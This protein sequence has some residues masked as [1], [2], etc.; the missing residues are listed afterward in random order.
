MGLGAAPPRTC[1]RQRAQQGAIDRGSGSG[2]SSS[3][4]GPAE[5]RSG[6]GSGSSRRGAA[7]RREQGSRMPH[8]PS[9]VTPDASTQVALAHFHPT[10]R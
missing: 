5:L 4:G 3:G 1:K 9:N 2:S 10:V 6:G 7:A 8:S